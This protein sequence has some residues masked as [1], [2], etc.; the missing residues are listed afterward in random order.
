MDAMELI[1]DKHRAINENLREATGIYVRAK[2]DGRWGSFD[3]ATLEKESLHKWLRSRGGENPWAEDVVGV[4]LGHG[5]F[6]S[7]DAG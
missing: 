6:S 1:V 7:E 5:S 2:C 3:I 4:L